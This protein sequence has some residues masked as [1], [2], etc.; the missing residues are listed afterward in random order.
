MSSLHDSSVRRRTVAIL[1]V[2]ALLGA[3]AGNNSNAAS[4]AAERMPSSVNNTGAVELSG[5]ITVFA[6]ASL[7]D[8][9]PEVEEAFHTKYPDVALTYNF[10]GSS[11]LVDQLE[12]GARADVLLT[13]NVTTME[14]AD[15]ADLIDDSYSFTS[16]TLVIVVP[17]GNP[18]GVT[19]LADG[20]LDNTKVV[21]C[22]PEV[23]CGEA[24]Q[25]LAAINDVTLQPV[26]E[27][28]AVTDVLGK[29]ASGEADAGLVYT[30][31]AQGAGDQLEV[32]EIE[33]A[34]Q[35]VND[36]RIAI[37]REAANPQ[38]AQAFTDFVLSER[39]QEILHAHG[40]Q[41]P[42]E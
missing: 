10:G 30:T 5:N 36:Y 19:G 16:N 23:P 14:N 39:G 38:A 33:N 7:I 40:F 13:A 18:A 21:I 12:G 8:V 17:A 42:V 6:A 26:S 34:D 22:A 4:T 24:T 31:D 1:A 11:G 41:D 32:I 35:V 9:L 2:C 25:K 27:E 29:V 20:S 15:D 37:L 28:Q 3:C